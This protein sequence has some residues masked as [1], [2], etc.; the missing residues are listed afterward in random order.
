[1]DILDEEIVDLWRGLHKHGVFYIMIGGFATNLHGFQRTT[2][3]IDLWIKDT[4]ENKK[5]LGIVLRDLRIADYKNIENMEFAPGWSTL[6]LNSGFELDIMTFIK[7]FEKDTFDKCYKL[8][9]IALMYEI[10]VKFLHINQLIQAKKASARPKD[11]LDV[12]ELEKIKN[13]KD[14]T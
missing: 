8:A 3:D 2:G 7:G 4:K 14:N 5:K 6:Y 12:I 9:P 1:M 11:R 10:P 13:R